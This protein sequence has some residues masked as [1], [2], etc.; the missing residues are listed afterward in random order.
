VSEK[1]IAREKF[2][3]IARGQSSIVDEFL[4]CT[5]EFVLTILIQELVRTESS[6]SQRIEEL[7]AENKRMREELDKQTKEK[8]NE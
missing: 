5:Q 2:Q 4:H 3:R 7:E 1:T 6:L 8:N